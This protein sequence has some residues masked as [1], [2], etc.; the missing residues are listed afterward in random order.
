MDQFADKLKSRTVKIHL[1]SGN[2]RS[3]QIAEI[4]NWSG[5]AIVTPRTLLKDCVKREELGRTG[6]YILSGQDANNSDKDRIYIGEGDIVA[7]RLSQHDKDKNK[8][9]WDKAVIVTSKDGNLTKS[10]VR[11]LESR[12]ITEAKK[13]GEAVLDNVQKIHSPSLPHLPAS[14]AADMEV[15]LDQI[16]VM[17]PIVGFS[18]FQVPTTRSDNSQSSA[19]VSFDNPV[20]SLSANGLTAKA[21]E[22]GSD[23]VILEGSQ[24]RIDTVSS[25]PFNTAKRRDDLRSE[26]K[27]VDS[28]QSDHLIFQQD[29]PFASPSTAAGVITGSSISGR[30]AWK[31]DKGQ[32]YGDWKDTELDAAIATSFSEEEIYEDNVDNMSSDSCVDDSEVINTGV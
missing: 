13:V 20:F 8:E 15:F 28:S 14:D 26:G 29:V 12:L 21:Q 27:L 32:S 19:S 17:L 1:P 22:I 18:Y 2:A 5:V 7:T 11:Y 31:D 30:V 23:F 24:A 16:L 10:H 4:F 25:I 3:I 6:I 9:F